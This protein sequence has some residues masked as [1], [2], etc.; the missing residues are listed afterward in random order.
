MGRSVEPQLMTLVRGTVLNV[1]SGGSFAM[2]IFP[3]QRVAPTIVGA[4][5]S[6]QFMWIGSSN[7]ARYEIVIMAANGATLAR[8]ARLEAAKVCAG[9]LCR[10]TVSW[11]AGSRLEFSWLV[12]AFDSAG[13]AYRSLPQAFS[14]PKRG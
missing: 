2:P 4:S 14:L 11:S 6:L 5:V 13:K 10:A 8:S 1:L 3:D 12:N 9:A 7:A